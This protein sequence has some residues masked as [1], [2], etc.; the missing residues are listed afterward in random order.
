M[1]M[2][3]GICG[4][5][6]IG[7]DLVNGQTIKT[8]EFIRYIKTRNDI[9][10]FLIVDTWMWKERKKELLKNYVCLFKKMDKVFL[11]PAHNGVK[12]FLPLA[13]LLNV[14]FKTEVYYMVIGGWLPN[15]IENNKWLV[16]VLARIDHIC[17]ETMAMEND[18]EKFNLKNVNVVHN[19]KTFNIKHYNVKE[20]ECC[21][22]FCTFSRVM[23]EKG[24]EDAIYVIKELNINS[25][26]KYYLDIYGPIDETYKE[27]WTKIN[28][29]LP[30]EIRY[31]GELDYNKASNVLTSYR[32]LLFPTYFWTEG[33]PG[34]IIDAYAA[35]IPV[36]AY[37]WRSA[38]EFIKQEKTGW[39]VETGDRNELENIISRISDEKVENIRKNCFNESQKYLSKNVLDKLF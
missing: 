36:I 7:T 18:L 35:G 11:F 34:T 21:S 6:G 17:V 37:R 28:N 2:K 13:I 25:K 16:K 32:A 15:F 33:L 27:R 30:K 20:R 23:K 24:I 1:D 31:C 12:I 5:V 3:V 29:E 14:L 26:N 10:D 38:D 19:S 8:K 4:C 9:E 39:I 22:K